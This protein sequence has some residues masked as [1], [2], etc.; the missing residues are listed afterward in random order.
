MMRRMLAE[1]MMDLIVHKS[2]NFLRMKVDLLEGRRKMHMKVQINI[3][4]LMK[5][6]QVK[7][8]FWH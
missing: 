5:V 3:V 6:I 8:G 7:D 1:V 4:K 2:S